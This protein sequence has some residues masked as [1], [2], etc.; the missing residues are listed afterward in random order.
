MNTNPWNLSDREAEV[1][2]AMVNSGGLAKVVAIDMCRSVKT[3]DTLYGRATQKMA[4]RTRT[5]ALLQF[6]RWM[7]ANRRTV[8]VC[9]TCNGLG[10]VY[11]DAVF[12]GKH[13]HG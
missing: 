5:Q 3:I 4:A 13:N 6:D 7:Q 11:Q 8:K 1:M 12:H 2:T 10:H 9:P